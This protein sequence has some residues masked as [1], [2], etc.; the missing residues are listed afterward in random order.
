MLI[1]VKYLISNAKSDASLNQD[2]VLPATG[3]KMAIAVLGA[4]PILAV[5]PFFQKYLIKGI[6]IGAVK[7]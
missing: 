5:Y 2:I 4:L 6:I 7:G 1:Y 3:I